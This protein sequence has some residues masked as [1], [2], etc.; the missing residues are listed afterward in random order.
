MDDDI[1]DDEVI[2]MIIQIMD[3]HEMKKNKT[4]RQNRKR[5]LLTIIRK[6]ILKHR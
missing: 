1:V 2:V 4:I 6:T 3:L 5:H